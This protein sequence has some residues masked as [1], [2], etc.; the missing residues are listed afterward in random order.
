MKKFLKLL[1]CL[2]IFLSP[3]A[4]SAACSIS[5]SCCDNICPTNCDVS[6]TNNCCVS[7]SCGSCSSSNDCT[8]CC[9]TPV[10]TFLHLRS[11]GANTARELVG[12]QWEINRPFMCE[13]YGA[14]YLAYEY[15]RS[16]RGSHLANGLFG[17]NTLS[18]SGSLAPTRCNQELLADNFGLAQ[19]FRGTVNFCP[20]IENHIFDLG[21]YLGLD[22][23]LQGAYLRIHAPVVY[24]RWNLRASEVDLIPSVTPFPACYMG[25]TTGTSVAP[26]ANIQQ[27]LSGSFLFGDL[28]M[29]LC[30][31]RVDFCRRNKSGL[32]DIDFIL[33]YNFCNTD[34]YHFGVYAQLVLPTGPR[35]NT[36]TLFSPQV[37]NNR[38]FEL[39]IGFSWHAVLC[40]TDHHNI[41]LFFEG[42]LTH[43]F[44]NTQCRTFDFCNA[45]A[46]SRYML[47]KG[48]DVTNAPVYNG[49]LINASC[50]TN[51]NVRVKLNVKGDASIKLAYRYC[52]FGID[53]GYNVYGH[54]HES[55]YLKDDCCINSSFYAIK[56]TSNVCCFQQQ[57]A[58]VS[59][60]GGF[61]P[62]VEPAGAV[63]TPQTTN[64]DPAV[65]TNFPALDQP[66]TLTVVPNNGS[67]PN[68]TAFSPA[69]VTG[70][71]G[72]CTVCLNAPVTTPTPV[73]TL[74]ASGAI[75]DSTPP[76]RFVSTGDLNLR[77]GAAPAVLT[78]KAFGF[79]NYTWFDSCGVNPNIGVGAE[80]E[81]DGGPK[82]GM[83]CKKVGL[84]Q[85]GIL[86][87]GGFSF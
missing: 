41:A 49:Q 7:T 73:A 8:A 42:N 58:N 51:Q 83:S 61:L 54:S 48:F 4:I 81:V 43:M 13:N 59:V 65:C 14:I 85:W 16:F 44:K 24:S 56:G 33:G 64:P 63:A 52:G 21:Y 80:V 60:A 87:K 23:W 40:G 71:A 55:L 82:T 18:F 9:I 75:L 72:T 35:V 45:G 22:C 37:G 5:S 38:H 50:F 46:F 31:G 70:T 67:Q 20:R 32:A 68:A 26:A 79:V 28:A 30:G 10:T 11:Q 78:H 47:L 19:N 6:A 39:G 3:Q 1:L 69:P 53:L 76:T 27:A 74:L 29:P 36:A 12:W 84:S 25:S 34:C 77:S 57:I 86:V 66:F 17:G 2:S 62:T 15:Q